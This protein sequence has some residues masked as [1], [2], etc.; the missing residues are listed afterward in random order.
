MSYR[1][2]YLLKWLIGWL[3]GSWP[4][5]PLTKK[6]LAEIWTNCPIIIPFAAAVVVV[7]GYYTNITPQILPM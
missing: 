6:Q 3:I 4:R 7:V 2:S 5:M 1:A